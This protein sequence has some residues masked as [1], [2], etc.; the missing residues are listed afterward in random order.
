MKSAP[1]SITLEKAKKQ[2]IVDIADLLYLT[3]L[4][5]EMEWGKGSSEEQKE[6]LKSMMEIEENRF[7][8]ENI[9]V[10]KKDEEL[11]GMALLIEGKDLDKFTINSDK[12]LLEKQK[13]WQNK[14]RFIGT[15][16]IDYFFCQ[17]C[18]EDEFY[19]SNIAVKAEHRGKGYAK[20]MIRTI[21]YIAKKKG[22]K[23]VSLLANNDKLVRFYETLGFQ[24]VNKRENKMLICI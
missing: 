7:S 21:N 5:P 1:C 3:E 15:A 19:I 12:K 9:V 6:R 24:V 2:D 4:E 16:F 14:I 8:L 11:I 17:E 13:G 20:S 18:K 23:K 22:Y 10:A